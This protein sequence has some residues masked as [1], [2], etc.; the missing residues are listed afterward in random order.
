[1]HDAALAIVRER[2]GL[3]ADYQFSEEFL[4]TM[5]YVEC[6]AVVIAVLTS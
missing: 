6:F 1:M 2:L 3:P 4:T 5:L